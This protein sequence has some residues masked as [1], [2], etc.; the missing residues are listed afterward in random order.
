MRAI[1]RLD[2]GTHWGRLGNRG[3]ILRNRRKLLSA[4]G[5]PGWTG[6]L[7]H[8]PA[9]FLVVRSLLFRIE[10]MTGILTHQT[11]KPMLCGRGKKN[12]KEPPQSNLDS[13][14]KCSNG[15]PKE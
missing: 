1:G 5:H 12:Q 14:Y 8:M 4:E 7:L 11:L 15:R 6:P 10:N 9:L 3:C 13:V 2:W